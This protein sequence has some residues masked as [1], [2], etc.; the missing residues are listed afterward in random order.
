MDT[1][2][3]GGNG[4]NGGQREGGRKMGSERWP[5]TCS[6]KGQSALDFFERFPA[7]PLHRLAHRRSKVIQLGGGAPADVV[8]L[9]GSEGERSIF[10]PRPVDHADVFVRVANAMD[11]Q[12]TRRNEGA[13]ARPGRRGPV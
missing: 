1:D 3:T 11:V 4:A 13:R 9:G 5:E 2:F 7:V 10:R 8:M 6:D 12:K